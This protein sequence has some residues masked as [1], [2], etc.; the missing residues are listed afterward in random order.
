MRFW[1]QCDRTRSLA[2]CEQNPSVI[3]TIAEIGGD[4]KSVIIRII[5][6]SLGITQNIQNRL[7]DP[8]FTTKQVGKGTGLG[9]FISYKIITEKH[10]GKIECFSDPGKGAEFVITL[11]IKAIINW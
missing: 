3:Q 5:D 10:R 6:N 11:P 4:G 1:G 9:L 2:E 8:F 7:F